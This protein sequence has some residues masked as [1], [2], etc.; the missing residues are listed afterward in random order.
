MDR[1]AYETFA[2]LEDHHFWFVARKRI[3]HALLDRE[4]GPRRDL[5]LLDVGCGAG[6]MLGPMQR[7]GTVHGV[8]LDEESVQWCR[9]RGFQDV[10]TGS[11]YELPHADATFDM[12]GLYDTIEHI[13][14]DHKA[15]TEALRVLRPGGLLFLSV[16]AYQFLWSQNDRIAHH[17]RRY[18]R[19]RLRRLVEGAGFEVRRITY[20][21]TV[22]LPLI[23][24]AV[25]WQKLLDRL[26]RLP[27]GYNNCSVPVPGPLNALFTL[28][29][30]AERWPLRWVDL[31]VG[32][33][34]IAI[35][36][37]PSA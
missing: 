10:Q 5:K 23:V 3:F 34:L 29:M 28:L 19:G 33:S 20:F 6:S 24:P 35:A 26:G 18:S 15:L 16:P 7:Y 27:E 12:V 30:G 9:N 4:I 37:K 22:L 11:A 13:P 17:Q 32:H 36:R 25:Y 2:R 1:I 31:P 14:D 8:D 21:N